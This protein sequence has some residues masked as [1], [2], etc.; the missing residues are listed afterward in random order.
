MFNTFS[1]M[2]SLTMNNVKSTYLIKGTKDVMKCKG[3][4]LTDVFAN[5]ICK[6]S[7]E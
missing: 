2:K 4:K 7:G 6:T 3:S 5:R 1:I